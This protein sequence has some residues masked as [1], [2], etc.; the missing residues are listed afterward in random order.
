MNHSLTDFIS[1]I[2]DYFQDE[3]KVTLFSPVV[4]DHWKIL[5][6]LN[7]PTALGFLLKQFHVTVYKI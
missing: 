5:C 7:I 1:L 4:T 6:D 3:N 2:L